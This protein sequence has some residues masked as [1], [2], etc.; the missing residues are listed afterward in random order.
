MS[1]LTIKDLQ[2]PRNVILCFSKLKIDFDVI[3]GTIMMADF[4]D[5]RLACTIKW[6]I[7]Y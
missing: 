7:C 3:V 2:T 5:G 1:F 4:S 6:E